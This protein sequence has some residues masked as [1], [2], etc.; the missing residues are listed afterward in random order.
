MKRAGLL[1]V[2]LWLAAL[3]LAGWTL[4]QLPLTDIGNSLRGLSPLQWML[5][6][7]LNGVVMA[8]STARWQGF[9]RMLGDRLALWPL[10]LNRMA[11]QTV[12]FLTPGPQFGGEPLQIYWL[13]RQHA[14]PVHRAVLALSLDRF[15]EL[16][17]NFAVLLGGVSLLL[18]TQ[19]VPSQDWRNT[20]LLLGLLVLALPLAGVLV[21]RQPGWVV[22]RLGRVATRWEQHPRL[23]EFSSKVGN[24]WQALRE[25]LQRTVREER[26]VL[27][28][29]LLLSVLG[30]AFIL[31]ELRALL[32]FLNVPVATGDFV[33][34]FVGIRLAMLLPLPGGIGTIEAAVLW[35]FALL[36]LSTGDALGL[37]ALM[38]LRDATILVFGLLSLRAMGRATAGGTGPGGSGLGGSGLGGSGPAREQS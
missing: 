27:L 26:P 20:L 16:W 33:L 35:T 23:Q 14:V 12:S 3:T 17:V 38:R 1:T 9:V 15:F 25:D 7:V 10:L 31:G 36:D 37:I 2:I 32:W 8:L 22:A 30:W 5:W 24:H 34:L 4:R 28:M 18:L 21:L 29:G 11:G 6:V 13:C 19:L